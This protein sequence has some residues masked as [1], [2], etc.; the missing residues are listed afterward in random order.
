MTRPDEVDSLILA[1]LTGG[2]KGV[3]RL[4]VAVRATLRFETGDLSEV[5]KSALHRLVASEAVV[6]VDGMY[7]LSPPLRRRAHRH[8]AVTSPVVVTKKFT[9]RHR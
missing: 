8:R 7:S 1:Q 5:V 9:M 6:D 2:E 3:L 4:I